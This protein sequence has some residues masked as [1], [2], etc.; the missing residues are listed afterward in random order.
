VAS[1]KDRQR[2]LARARMER[3]MARQAAAARKKRQIQAGIGA[4]VALI[5]IVFGTVWLAGG[6]KS[7]PKPTSDVASGSCEWVAEQASDVIKDTGIPPTSGEPRSGTRT[8][9]IKTNVGEVEAELDLANAPCTAAS[10]DYLSGLKFFDKTPCHRLTTSGIYVLQCG[11]PSGTGRGGPGYKFKDE[12]LPVSDT[13]TPEPSATAP[14]QAPTNLYPAGT[15]AMA[16][17]G[18]NTNG[19]QFF[20]VYKDGSGL[21]GN[22]TIFGKITKGLD[23]VTKV[24]DAGAVD[25]SGKATQDGAPKT[26]VTI[27]TLTLGPAPGQTP[28]PTP[29]PAATSLPATPASS[30]SPG[31]QS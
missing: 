11:D 17:S 16:N 2:K 28:A 15:I 24:A 10:F 3:R 1:S 25:T 8:M 26:K 19:S 20:I 12:N 27:E 14:A 4:S 23:V 9:T 31:D 6:F 21:A 5:L 13:P 22:Y 30:A 18:P 29:A 7:K